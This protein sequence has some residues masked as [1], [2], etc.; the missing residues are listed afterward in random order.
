MRLEPPYEH[1]DV[2]AERLLAR[3]DDGQGR[4]YSFQ[5]WRPRRYQT[6]AQV[7]TSDGP[8]AV[9]VVP[10]WHPSRPVRVLAST[11]PSQAREPGSWLNVNAD[12]SQSSPSQLAV[13]PIAACEP[14]A[15]AVC[16][17]P[18]W[19]PSAVGDRPGVSEYGAGCGDI[20]L[21]LA[22]QDSAEL[23]NQCRFFVGEQPQRIKA[24]GRIYLPH[25]GAV[26][27]Y[28]RL[29]R[30]RTLPNG[31][32]LEG[33]AE[34]HALNRTIPLEGVKETGAWRWRWWPRAIERESCEDD[35]NRYRYDPREHRGGYVW[36]RAP[37]G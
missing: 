27:V 12:L 4:H 1:I 19:R 21:E 34:L 37:T 31:A 22:D 2:S 35:I 8:H 32:W 6:W 5:G 28:R 33:E 11:L 10:E 15:P 36:R 24:G 23:L 14:P 30:C 17:S 9:L 25:H 7:V 29:V 13:A 18:N 20:V 26:S 16:R 3:R